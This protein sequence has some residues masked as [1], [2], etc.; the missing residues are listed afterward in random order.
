VVGRSSCRIVKQLEHKNGSAMTSSSGERSSLLSRTRRQDASP[1]TRGITVGILSL[2]IA[3]FLLAGGNHFVA[4]NTTFETSNVLRYPAR[5]GNTKKASTAKAPLIPRKRCDWLS[6]KIQEKDAGKAEE[7]LRKQYAAQ[8][9][10]SNVFFRATAHVFWNDFVVGN[11][12]NWTLSTLKL[13]KKTLDPKSTYTWVTGDQHLSNF[14]AWRNRH[15][16][17]VFGVNDFDE[18]AIYD[19]HIDVLRIAVSICNH[20]ITNGLSPK[21]VNKALHVFTDSYVE[22]VIDYVGNE[23]ALLFELT[24][25]TSYGVLKTFLKKVS[26]SNSANKQLQKF[27]EVDE[28][29][30]IRH[31]IEGGIS[32]PDNKTSLANVPPEIAQ[33]IEAAFSPTQYGATMMKLGWHV[34]QWDN[35][36]FTVL[37]VA[38]RVGSGVGSF[39]VDRYYVLL[40]GTDGLLG[41]DGSD[42]SAVILDI[43]E[44]PFAAVE[45]VLSANDAA[46]YRIMFANAAARVVEAQR[47]LTSYVDPFT[48]WFLFRNEETGISTPISVRQR[49]PWKDSI[50]LDDLTKPRDFNDFIAQIAAATATSHVRGTVAKAPAQFKDIIHSIMKKDKKNQ[51]KWGK[52]V[53]ELAKAYHEQV[54]LDFECFQAFVEMNYGTQD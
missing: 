45:R 10:D 40:K 13:P 32:I 43:K 35:D 19:F 54:L 18:A 12:G 11:W 20:A 41:E 17:V 8:S 28:T 33:Q 3:I 47:R 26:K 31:F 50:D 16:K 6:E 7:D 52:A 37:D 30:G 53:A 14:G 5:L 2:G 9:L 34:R 22:A 21:Q 1:S 44:Q 15:G 29:T 46:W 23:K 39:G 25:D 4:N 42:G 49:S 48:G 27:T 38:E 24:P 36:Y 51:K